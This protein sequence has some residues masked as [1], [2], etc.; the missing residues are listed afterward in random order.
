MLS[1]GKGLSVLFALPDSLHCF[2]IYF[3][4]PHSMYQM[5][6]TVEFR[7]CPKAEWKRSNG[8]VEYR[9]KCLFKLY[10]YLIRAH[11]FFDVHLP[12]L[13][14]KLDLFAENPAL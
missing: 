3:N 4:Y 13:Q 6:Y 1:L 9:S 8:L 12:N 7:Y 14:F 11:L 10:C 5:S 2:T